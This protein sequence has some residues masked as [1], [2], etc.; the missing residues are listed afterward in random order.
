MNL[1]WL[2]SSPHTHMKLPEKRVS[3]L[4]IYTINENPFKTVKDKKITGDVLPPH[5]T[6]REKSNLF[7]YLYH[8]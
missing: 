8:Q 7:A 5:K 2:M 6:A 4:H 1:L 3:S